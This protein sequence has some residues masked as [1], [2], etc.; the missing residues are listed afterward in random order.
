MVYI[1]LITVVFFLSFTTKEH[2]SDGNSLKCKCDRE[3]GVMNDLER[4]SKQA[5]K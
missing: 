2:L 1:A 4:N 3:I 5:M